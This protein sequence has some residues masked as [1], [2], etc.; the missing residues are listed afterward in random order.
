[1]A[2]RRS[3]W[4]LVMSVM[5]AMW[6]QSIP[7]RNPRPSAVSNTPN[8]NPAWAAVAIRPAGPTD[9]STSAVPGLAGAP[10]TQA[11]DGE[12]GEVGPKPPMAREQPPELLGLPEREGVVGTGPGA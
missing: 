1:M 5:A 12:V 3:S 4:E 7:C 10:R 9:G 6:S 2:W 11:R 8:R